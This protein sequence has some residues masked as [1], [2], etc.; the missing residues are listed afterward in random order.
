MREADYQDFLDTSKPPE[1]L[2]EHL[3]EWQAS[4]THKRDRF[5]S[6]GIPKTSDMNRPHE[7]WQGE[8]D[9]DRTTECAMELQSHSSSLEEEFRSLTKK[10]RKE[11][12]VFSSVTKKILHP[13]YQRIIGMGTPA[14]P[15]I[16]RELQRK[17]GHWFWALNAISGEDPVCPED[18]FDLAVEKWLEWGRSKGYL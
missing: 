17:P 12:A 2:R 7:N 9:H 8:D 5:S 1:C 14:L 11:T 16:L 4:Q 10:W 13:A 3:E 18:D 15:L 6:Y